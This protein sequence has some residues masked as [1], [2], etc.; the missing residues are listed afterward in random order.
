MAKVQ[1]RAC[2]R[3]HQSATSAKLSSVLRLFYR[4]LNSFAI[5]AKTES[6]EHKL[7]H[8]KTDTY[9]FCDPK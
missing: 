4:L 5:Q 6:F 8:L 2:K 9:L 7:T 1:L 3:F